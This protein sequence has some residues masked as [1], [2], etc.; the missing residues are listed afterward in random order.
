MLTFVSYFLCFETIYQIKAERESEQKENG[1]DGPCDEASLPVKDTRY[2][3][4]REF[5][6]RK[7]Y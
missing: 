7:M 5:F 2:A 3:L 4:A 6:R 1:E